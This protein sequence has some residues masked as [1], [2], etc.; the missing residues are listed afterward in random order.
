MK[1]KI[2]E[3]VLP[4]FDILTLIWPSPSQLPDLQPPEEE[5]KENFRWVISWSSVSSS[6]RCYLDS[7]RWRRYP[8]HFFKWMKLPSAIIRTDRSSRIST[9]ISDLILASQLLERMELENLPC[10]LNPWDLSLNTEPEGQYQD[11]DGWTEPEFW[12]CH[13]KR[14]SPRVSLN[15]DLWS[16]I[17]LI[18]RPSGY[19]AQHHVDTLIPTMSPVQFLASR[20]PGRT[21]QE[22]RSHLGNFQISGMTGYVGVC[23]AWR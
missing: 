19:F 20:F 17:S 7:L 5:E 12:S 18:Q 13:S 11:F 22:Y 6:L 14:S 10:A 21:E 23:G 16:W 1:I 3:K 8:H 15:W 9:L 4:N 2:L